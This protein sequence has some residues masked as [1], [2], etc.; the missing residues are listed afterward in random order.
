MGG[1]TGQ[2][3]D[4]VGVGEDRVGDALE[5]QQFVGPLALFGMHEI[6]LVAFM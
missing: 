3:G 2:P 4:G 1:E 5:A 6:H